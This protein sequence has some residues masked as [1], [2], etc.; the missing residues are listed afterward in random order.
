MAACATSLRS[1][2][3]ETTSYAGDQT[4]S[5]SRDWWDGCQWETAN[6][7]IT[8]NVIDF[9]PAHIKDCNHQDWKDC[10]AGGVFSEYGSPPDHEPG[11]VVAT[12]VT[13][14]RHNEWADNVYKGPSTFYAW[15][16]GSG[17]NP[18][19]W[20]AWTSAVSSDGGDRCS[21]ADERHSGYCTG[22][23]GQDADSSYNPAPLERNPRPPK[24]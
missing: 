13:F 16:Q 18:V 12:E 10:G 22:P 23:F 15:N 20:G 14:Y 24:L 8:R 2:A 17:D 21:S 19:G 7:S 11:W 3:V 6:V 4:G 5:P 9:N 1:A